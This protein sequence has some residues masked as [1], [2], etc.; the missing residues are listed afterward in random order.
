MDLRRRWLLFEDHQRRALVVGVDCRRRLQLQQHDPFQFKALDGRRAWQN[1]PLDKQRSGM[2]AGRCRIQ[3]E[4]ELDRC[5]ERFRDLRGRTNGSDHA[6]DQRRAIVGRSIITGS[7][8]LVLWNEIHRSPPRMGCRRRRYYSPDHR[9][10]K[11]G[12]TDQSDR[13]D[14]PRRHVQF[15]VRRLDRRG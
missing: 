6:L 15:G 5:T 3:V 11:L 7:S 14:A 13:F 12:I 2:V 9:R 4:C 8:G 10:R 1:L